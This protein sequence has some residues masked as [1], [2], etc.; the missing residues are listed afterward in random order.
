VRR[1][2]A[3]GRAVTLTTTSAEDCTMSLVFE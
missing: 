1:T 2:D 3:S